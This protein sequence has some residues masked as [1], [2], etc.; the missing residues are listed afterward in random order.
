[1][2]TKI[3][4]SFDEVMRTFLDKQ[5]NEHTHENEAWYASELGFCKR[6]QVFRRMGIKVSNPTQWRIRFVARDGTALHEWR[7]DAAKKQGV[8]ILSEKRLVDKKTGWRGRPDLLVALDGKPVMLDIKTQRSEA[9]FRRNRLPVDQR[10][11][12]YHKMQ[13]GSYIYFLNKNYPD[14]VEKFGFP[15][16]TKVKEGRIYFVDRGGGIREEYVINFDKKIFKLI[17]QELKSLNTFWD[18]KVIPPVEEKTWLCRFC[19]FQTQCSKVGGQSITFNN[20]KKQTYGPKSKPKT[21]KS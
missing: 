14:I 17:T 15:K 5:D 9:F 3:Y 2:K 7:E 4:S 16:G 18:S 11:S 20:F 19:P 13:L 10:I 8:V 1:M 6:K 12:L 21:K